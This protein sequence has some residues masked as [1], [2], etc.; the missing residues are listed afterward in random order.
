MRVRSLLWRVGEPLNRTVTRTSVGRSRRKS[1][2]A[3]PTCP[4]CTGSA[5]GRQPI[6]GPITGESGISCSM[7]VISPKRQKC[8]DHSHRLSADG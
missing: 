8:V 6:T 4:A 3:T 7:R 1:F 2:S 5:T